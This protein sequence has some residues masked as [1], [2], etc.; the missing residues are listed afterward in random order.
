MEP[1]FLGSFFTS[2][3]F[4]ISCTACAVETPMSGNEKLE[5]ARIFLYY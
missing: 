2:F 1:S 3:Y 5:K 4:I